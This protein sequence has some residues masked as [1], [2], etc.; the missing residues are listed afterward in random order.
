[1]TTQIEALEKAKIRKIETH[2]SVTAEKIDVKR[3]QLVKILNN[4][5]EAK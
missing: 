2:F 1:M 4:D 5:V 3:F